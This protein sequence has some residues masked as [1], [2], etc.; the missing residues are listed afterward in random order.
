MLVITKDKSKTRKAFT[1]YDGGLKRAT[2][3]GE[4]NSL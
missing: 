4:K 2:G 1:V 3:S